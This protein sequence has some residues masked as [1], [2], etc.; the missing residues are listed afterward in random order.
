[1]KRFLAPILFAVLLFPALAMGETMDDLMKRDGFYYRNS[2][3]F[4]SRGRSLGKNRGHSKTV[5]KM[6]L[7]SITTRTDSYVTKETG[8]TIRWTVLGLRLIRME[9]STQTSQESTRTV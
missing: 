9:L 8:R 7:G 2:P 6:V 5:R 1:M 4:P 3:M